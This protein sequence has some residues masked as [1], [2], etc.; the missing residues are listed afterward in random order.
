MLARGIES[1]RRVWDQPVPAA[2]SRRHILAGLALFFFVLQGVTGILLL[3]YYRPS[4][5]AAYHSIGVINDEVNLGWLVRSLHVWGSD[6]LILCG[7]LHLL[8]VYFARAYRAPRRF[9]WVFGML[10]MV[11]V[12]AFGFTG[13]LLPWDQFAYW[14]VD[15]AKDTIAAIPVVGS[16][17]LNVFW[18]GWDLGE[19]VLLRFYAFHVAILPW[20]AIGCLAGHLILSLRADGTPAADAPPALA[21]RV[22]VAD[23]ALDALA[24]SLLVGGLLLTVAVVYPQPLLAPADP[25][26]PLP[27]VQP[28]WYLLPARWLLRHLPGTAGAVVVAT[29]FIVLLAVPF[30]DRKP[31]E[32]A[33]GGVIRWSLG[34]VAVAAWLFM[35]L[36]QYLS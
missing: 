15:A 4:V 28:R 7:L 5:D 10:L 20:I 19:E 25:L 21:S 18:G 36:M 24:L 16:S 33:A 13:G 22:T 35:A 14:S 2:L 12:L 30:I 8:R 11:V 26:S 17:L 1:V 31:H 23:G 34:I 29:L 6:L 3:V 9:G 32:S 27:H